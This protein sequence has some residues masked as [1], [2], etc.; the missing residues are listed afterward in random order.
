MGIDFR[1]FKHLSPH[2]PF[3]QDMEA[4]EYRK[5]KN[6]D[7]VEDCKTGAGLMRKMCE[8]RFGDV[9]SAT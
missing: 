2:R 4:E 6:K 7:W 8:G 9:P 1:C 5:I 3:A